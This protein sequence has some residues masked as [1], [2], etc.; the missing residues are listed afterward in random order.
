MAGR[1]RGPAFDFGSLRSALEDAESGYYTDDD[2]D[3]YTDSDGEDDVVLLEIPY[4]LRQLALQYRGVPCDHF[5]NRAGEPCMVVHERR[6]LNRGRRDKRYRE[7]AIKVLRESKGECVYQKGP[8]CPGRLSGPD[9]P[10]FQLDHLYPFNQGG[11]DGFPNFVA[12]CI[13]CNSSKKHVDPTAYCTD[14][15][16]NWACNPRL[17]N[18]MPAKPTVPSNLLLPAG[19]SGLVKLQNLMTGGSSA[20]LLLFNHQCPPCRE[21]MPVFVRVARHL[22]DYYDYVYAIDVTGPQVSGAHAVEQVLQILGLGA[23]RPGTP[24]FIRVD[25]ADPR[26]RNHQR[27]AQFAH[28]GYHTPVGARTQRDCDRALLRIFGVEV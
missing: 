15:G 24:A 21:A 18:L 16:G 27:R 25:E 1:A 10:K 5:E 3:N 28:V 17:R 23:H 19:R 12:S 9:D 7:A 22:D 11:Y 8:N 20:A 13:S 4:K 2:G 14:E 6:L 26:K